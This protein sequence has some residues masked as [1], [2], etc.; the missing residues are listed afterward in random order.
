MD[1]STPI[2][3]DDPG[4]DLAVLTISAPNLTP[5]N[6]GDSRSIQVGQVVIAIGNPYG[7]QYTDLGGRSR[8][9]LGCA[10]DQRAQPHAS[11]FWRLALHSGRAGGNRDR[12]SLWIS[13]HRSRGTIP[14]RTW[15]C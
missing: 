11:E 12:Q 6:F 15:L 10:D 2:S 7:F 5:A 14:V 4:T 3:G 13:V 8:Y 1:F 9:G